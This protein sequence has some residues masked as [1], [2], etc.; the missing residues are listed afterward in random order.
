MIVFIKY[1]A[2]TI[3]D[4]QTVKQVIASS[5]V[6]EDMNVNQEKK[7]E[8][9]SNFP[10]F[11]LWGICSLEILEYLNQEKK[12]KSTSN[13]SDLVTKYFDRVHNPKNH[14]K[15]VKLTFYH[16]NKPF[17]VWITISQYQEMLQ[18]SVSSILN[19]FNISYDKTKT[20][21]TILPEMKNGEFNVN[22]KKIPC[23]P[24]IDF[25]QMI[26]VMLWFAINEKNESLIHKKLRPVASL[27]SN[28]VRKLLHGKLST[29]NHKKD[30]NI[31]SEEFYKTLCDT[32]ETKAKTIMA[33]MG[34]NPSSI[35]SCNLANMPHE[36]LYNLCQ[37]LEKQPKTAF[38][39]F[40]LISSYYQNE[41]NKS[42]F[43]SL[44]A[45]CFGIGGIL[46]AS[47]T[48]EEESAFNNAIQTIESAST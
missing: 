38:Y 44:A 15:N 45:L 33:D 40:F 7:I 11:F 1:I 42:L 3:T 25:V 17:I 21:Q 47:T 16:H 18:R 32:L 22:G 27:A 36:H 12:D 31:N 6:L 24:I 2:A 8:L 30:T 9:N 35:T 48:A 23:L 34:N 20:K 43:K 37:A 39:I 41:S 13:Y 28:L 46:V 26:I 29:L 19:K 5:N 4:T 10:T 14:K